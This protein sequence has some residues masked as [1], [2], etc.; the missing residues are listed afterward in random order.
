MKFLERDRFRSAM[1]LMLLLGMVLLP[2]FVVAAGSEGSTS[3]GDEIKFSMGGYL[4]EHVSINLQDSPQTKADD[5]FTL[6]MARSTLQ[7]EADASRGDM[8]VHAVGRVVGELE[9]DFLR[10][11]NQLGAN[12][13]KLMEQYNFSDLRELYLEFPLSSRATLRLGKQQ[14]VWGETDFF[15]AM[16]VL[17]GFDF[18]WRSFLEGENEDYRKPLIFANATVQVPELNG[19]LQLLLRPG[20]DRDM[21]IGSTYDFFGGRWTVTPFQGTNFLNPA[22]FPYNFHHPKGDAKDI[23]WAA[24]WLGKAG[25]I[26]YS[27]AYIRT[28][29]PD[30]VFNPSWNPYMGIPVTPGAGETIF[31]MND[32]YGITMSGYSSMADAVFSTEIVYIKDQAYDYGTISSPVIGLSGVIVKDTVS[33]MIRMDKTLNLTS[34]LGTNQPSFFSVQLFDKWIQSFN[35]SDHVTDFAGYSAQRKEH[36]TIATAVLGLNYMSSRVNPQIAGGYDF[37]YGGSFLIPSVAIAFGDQWRLNVEADLFFPK[38]HN[39]SPVDDSSGTHLLGYFAHKDQLSV[40]LTRQ[41]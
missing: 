40:R 3:G 13:G 12:D 36:S 7:V 16:D 39:D 19:S 23:T 20:L 29:G 14:V 2:G 8:K 18:T 33:S 35:P 34:I 25:P 9:T 17:H 10:R 22:A 31:L 11:L 28:L 1:V 15:Q 27:L 4:R 26:T 21:D 37:S 6:Q 41:F 32:R 5:K 24:R 38:H 30:P